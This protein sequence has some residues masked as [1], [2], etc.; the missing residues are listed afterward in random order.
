[1]AIVPLDRGLLDLDL[2]AYCSSPRAISAHSAGRWPDQN[3]SRGEAG[4]LLE[5]HVREHAAGEAYAYA[6]LDADHSRE[7]GC[8][9]LLPLTP[10]LA[11]TGT[12]L[13]STTINPGR[14]A[15]VTFWLIDDHDAR[16]STAAVLSIL[17]GWLG[18]WQAA[19]LLYR[20][21]P[22]ESASVAVLADAD[23]LN[24]VVATRQEL[25][26]L[27]FADPH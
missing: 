5:L 22:E 20:C 25:P 24:A 27:W 16:P 8:A 7:L 15:I 23:G 2:A 10:F 17:R 6:I 26:Y 9:Y 18:R 1:M 14:T 21:L 12:R 4:R 3:L 13:D 11:R 19:E